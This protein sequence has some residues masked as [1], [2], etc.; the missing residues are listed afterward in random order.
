MSKRDQICKS[1]EK[2]VPKTF[3][4]YL[5]ELL[6][7]EKVNF[8]ITKPRN[9]KHGDYRP[10]HNGKTHRITVNNDLNKYAF[11]I[12]TIHE[13]A[14]MTTHIK[15]GR[16]IKAHGLEWKTEFKRLLLPVLESKELPQSIH[17]ALLR[18]LNN[19]KASSCTDKNLY[20]ALKEFDDSSKNSVLLEQL[21]NNQKFKL[22]KKVFQ[23]GVLRRSR[24]L[25]EEVTSR[26]IYLVSALA[27]VEPVNEGKE[28][29]E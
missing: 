18:S 22:G 6:F 8:K 14:H 29:G 20:R 24:F 1:F 4:P 21:K 12:T 2:Y 5:V 13:F 28:D 23:R 9:T 25:C 10:P 19:L 3:A 15:Y 16:G 26:K 11:L 7:S 17:N 27:E